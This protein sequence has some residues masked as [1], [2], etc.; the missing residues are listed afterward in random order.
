MVICNPWA[1][2]YV[3]GNYLETTPLNRALLLPAGEHVLEL[4]NPNFQTVRQKIVVE[5]SRSDTIKI[6]LK[7]DNGFI[8]VQVMPW[9]DVYLDDRFVGTT[10]LEKPL[11]VAAGE[12]NLKLVNPNYRTMYD[13]LT[14][15]S[16][17]LI[18]KRIRLQ[19]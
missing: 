9:A 15:V 10:P 5:Q 8:M 13:T 12:H 1:K 7:P 6:N 3:D 16:G 2:I 19:K 11:S 17:E 4:K 18:E 14:V